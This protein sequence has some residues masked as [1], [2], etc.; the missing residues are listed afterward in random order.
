MMFPTGAH[1]MFQILTKQITDQPQITA[2]INH[3]KYRPKLELMQILLIQKVLSFFLHILRINKNL[4]WL[5]TSSCIINMNCSLNTTVHLNGIWK[6]LFLFSLSLVMLCWAEWG[7]A[8]IYRSP[9]G[10]RHETWLNWIWKARHQPPDDASN[11]RHLERNVP[12][13]STKYS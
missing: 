11:T 1:A 4:F 10:Q 7:P 13:I 9:T 3:N 12:S 5:E 8:W 6:L 2:V